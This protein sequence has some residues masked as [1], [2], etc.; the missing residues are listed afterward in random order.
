MTEQRRVLIVG[1]GYVG[2]R[3][4]VDLVGH[5]SEVWVTSRSDE[6]LASLSRYG[7]RAVRL[8]LAH[9]ATSP[10]WNTEFDAVV[11]AVAP[12]RDGNAELG[13]R[14]GIARVL[15]HLPTAPARFVHLSS[16]GVYPQQ[17]GEAVDET[18]DANPTERR[19]A[20][21]RAGEELALRSVPGAMVL[22]LAG[23]YGTERSP[24]EWLERPAMRERLAQRAGDAWMNWLRVEDA[25]RAIRLAL[26]QGAGG[27]IYNVTDGTPVLRRDFFAYAAEL[28]G[29][30]ALSFAE[31]QDTDDR[32]KRCST[33][34]AQLEL[35]YVPLFPSFRE[36]L[37]ELRG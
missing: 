6:R 19:H 1:A 24:L 14:D 9:P 30:D 8:D 20:L 4:G 11:Y 29:H 37:S 35:G 2:S 26:A 12:G 17:R 15:E 32:G 16:T 33:K 25:V 36:G 5:G 3:L 7:L 21:I 31:T 22:R 13:F 23:L 27:E 10:C 28:N 18:S 34:K